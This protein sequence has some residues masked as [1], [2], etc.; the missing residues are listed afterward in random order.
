MG[1]A[2]ARITQDGMRIQCRN[3]HGHPEVAFFI[4]P[5]H[6]R[7]PLSEA[8]DSKSTRSSRA[9]A[10]PGTVA[11]LLALLA[12]AL[13]GGTSP[14]AVAVLMAG[15]GLAAAT[16]P[17]KRLRHGF[18]VCAGLVLAVALGWAWPASLNQLPWRSR[19]E[20]AGIPL[21]WYTSPEPWVSLRAWLLL[22]GGLVWAGWCAGQAWTSRSRI[23]VCE[24]LAAG[25]GVI[26]FVALAT[27]NGH[28]P[29]WPKGTGLGPFANR[30]QTATLF[31]TGAFLTVACGAERFRRWDVSGKRLRQLMAWGLAWFCLLGV[32]TAALALDLSRFGPILFAGMTLAWVLTVMPL[33]KRKLETLAAWVAIGLLLGTVFLLTGRTVL[34]RLAASQMV[35]FR[36]KIFSDALGMIRAS[37]WTGTGLGCFDTIFPLYRNASILQE[38]VLHPESDWLWLAAETGLPGVLAMAGLA[39]WMGA[40]AWRGLGRGED[41]AMRLAVCV[42]CLGVLAHSFVDV[43]GHRL[44]TVMP[45]LLLLG[46]VAGADHM[47]TRRT[48][49]LLRGA[50]LAVLLLGAGS[51]MVLAL[52]I[53]APLLNGPDA[54]IAQAAE[55]EAAGRPAQAAAALEAALKWTPL[56]WRLYAGRAEIEGTR[57]ELTA[58]LGDFRRARFLEPDYAGLPFDEGVYWLAVAPG[59]TIEAWAEALRR[60]PAQRRAELYQDMLEHAYASHPELHGGLWSMAS[61]DSALE[62]VCFGWAPPEEFKAQIDAVLREDP[63]LERFSAGQLRRLFPIWMEKGDAQRLALLL[64]QRTEWLAAGYRTL[65]EYDAES[66]NLADA[67]AL[68][69]RYLPAPR[70]PSVTGLRHEEAARRFEEDQGDLAAGLTLYSEA[71]AAGRDDEALETLQRM[72]ANADCPAYAHYLEGQLLVKQ[73]KLGEAWKQLDQYAEGDPR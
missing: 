4:P 66:G 45:A 44:G 47:E 42:A 41:R 60:I 22:L 17:A 34:A 48:A 51:L 13:G 39:G 31:A 57:G 9:A 68:M 59:F 6:T 37:P 21:D 65:A 40:Q 70:V 38:R 19:L 12:P 33:R 36:L 3:A 8:P 24:G 69:E 30:N 2:G 28:V 15:I 64:A 25:I 55:E 16:L 49:W 35:D 50:G 29:G 54:L 20:E 73:G 7:S 53:P 71:M 14:A 67:V 52:R 1:K 43:P 11:V 23:G 5:L 26:A 32:Y 61:T 63:A 27:R 18:L 56:D 10:L 58:A 72:S 46:L 62:M